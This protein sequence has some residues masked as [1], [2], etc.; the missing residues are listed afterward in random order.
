MHARYWIFVLF[1][2]LALLILSPTEYANALVGFIVL[3]AFFMQVF[4]SGTIKYD[5]DNY[6]NNLL[7]LA[8]DSCQESGY[9]PTFVYY[10]RAIIKE[11][12]CDHKGSMMDYERALKLLKSSQPH[13]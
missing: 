4:Y 1:T 8:A 12:L 3:F 9:K 7:H 11:A 13:Q 10:F 6:K 2:V 5:Y